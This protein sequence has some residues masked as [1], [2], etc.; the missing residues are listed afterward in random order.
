MKMGFLRTGTMTGLVAATVS[1]AVLAVVAAQTGEP[2]AQERPTIVQET[3]SG[4]D[5]FRT[6]CAVCHGT[7]ARGDGPLADSLK[8]RPPD[9][10]GIAARNAGVFPSD[11]VFRI[12][13]GR[14]RVPGHGG[15]DMPVWGDAFRRSVEGGDAKAVRGRIEALVKYL[16]GIQARP[17]F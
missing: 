14:E 8:R 4:E 1:A 13:D 10:T 9:L 5:L 16:D 7:A 2:G 11:K 17:G 12:I 6:Y 3:W 15:T